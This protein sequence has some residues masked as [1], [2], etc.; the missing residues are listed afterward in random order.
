[1]RKKERKKEGRKEGRNSQQLKGEASPA[2]AGSSSLLFTSPC[3]RAAVG[4]IE[5]RSTPDPRS[6]RAEKHSR[7]RKAGG[8]LIQRRE[9]SR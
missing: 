3:L 2:L 9:I 8:C 1:V 5:T 7:P 6:S 4:K